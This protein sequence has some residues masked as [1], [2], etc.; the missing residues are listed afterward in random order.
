[1]Q[2]QYVGDIGDYGK[3]GLLRSLFPANS[4]WRLGIV[5]YLV[6]NETQKDDGKYIG[7]LGQDKYR[8]CDPELFDALKTIVAD[9][10]RLVQEISRANI[11][12]RDTVFYNPELSFVDTTANSERGRRHRLAIRSKWL[13]GALEATRGCQ[14][15]FL[16]PDNGIQAASVK[17]HSKTGPKYAF[18]DEIAQ[19]VSRSHVTLVY[20]H[21]SRQGKHEDQIRS[22]RG[23]LQQYLDHNGSLFALRFR[24]YSPRAFFVIVDAEYQDEIREQIRDF[25]GTPWQKYCEWIQ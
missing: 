19:F 1:M 8:G 25:M 5:W 24:P 13:K 14:A 12:S 4:R 7:Y 23:Q 2:N 11:F 6:P 22:R 18:L 17:P 20:H 3:Y 10:R 9:N 21:L 15:V 16:D